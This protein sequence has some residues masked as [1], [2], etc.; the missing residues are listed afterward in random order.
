MLVTAT[1]LDV[2]CTNVGHEVFKPCREWST[3]QQA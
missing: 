1:N 2:E 3:H